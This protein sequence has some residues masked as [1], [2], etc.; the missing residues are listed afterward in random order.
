MWNGASTERERAD[1]YWR[2]QGEI[3]PRHLSTGETFM[4]YF[5]SVVFDGKGKNES[6]V[7]NTQVLCF[8]VVT[9]FELCVGVWSWPISADLLSWGGWS[10][11]PVWTGGRCSTSATREETSASRS[12]CPRCRRWT[13]CAKTLCT[14]EHGRSHWL[15]FGLWRLVSC[16]SERH[17]L[18][19]QDSAVQ[20]VCEKGLREGALGLF[21]K[22]GEQHNLNALIERRFESATRLCW[23][24]LRWSFL[25]SESYYLRSL[26]EDV[27]K[28]PGSF[29]T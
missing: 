20:W 27:R 24:K 10:L 28:V 19:S 6:H 22:P 18:S 9:W 3:P 1:L 4:S 16:P 17:L 5:I 29:Q 2:G 11:D 7:T 15:G 25:Q 21:P 26:G 14:S 23:H 8:S 13:S 12:T